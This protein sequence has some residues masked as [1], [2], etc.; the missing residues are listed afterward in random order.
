MRTLR[1]DQL[2]GLRG[3]A[4]AVVV[5]FHSILVTDPTLIWRVLLPPFAAMTGPQDMAIKVALAVLNGHT[6]VAI[7]FV[8]SGAVLFDSL[9]RQGGAVL[10][11]V[12]R[13]LRIYPALGVAVLAGAAVQA[14]MGHAPS[15]QLLL[16]NLALADFSIIGAAWTLQ[17]E[18]V[19]VPFILL[20]FWWYRWAGLP[21]L[22]AAFLAAFLVVKLP[23]LQPVLV[24]TKPNLLPFALG[25]M[26]TTPLGDREAVIRL[27]V[28][29]GIPGHDRTP[30]SG[31]SGPWAK[32]DESGPL[33]DAG[34]Q[35]CA[36][37]CAVSWPRRAAW[38]VSGAA[39]VTVSWPD[40]LWPLSIQCAAP[41]RGNTNSAGS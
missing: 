18:L 13:L 5:V 28:R 29:G 26:I 19:A 15:P 41:D 3:Y 6:A 38:R 27:L 17:V 20:S 22:F 11:I 30:Y 34:Q 2:D 35:C 33:H 39:P 10:F 36:G 1:N 24:W 31:D 40:Q 32:R 12:R 23:A 37:L 9:Q 4:A 8:L 7:F 21:G 14:V 25:F 16:S